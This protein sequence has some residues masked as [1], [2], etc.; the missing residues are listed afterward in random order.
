MGRKPTKKTIK[1][2]LNQTRMEIMYGEGSGWNTTSTWYTK[3]EALSA[4]ARA[5]KHDKKKYGYNQVDRRVVQQRKYRVVVKS[6]KSRRRE[7]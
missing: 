5:S 1:K 2:R 7:T 4:I 3:R 6:L